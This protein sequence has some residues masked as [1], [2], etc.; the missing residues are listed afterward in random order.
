MYTIVELWLRQESP[1]LLTRKSERGLMYSTDWLV[2]ANTVRAALLTAYM[3]E[4][5]QRL[6]DHVSHCQ[7]FDNICRASL[8]EVCGNC[9]MRQRCP[10]YVDTVNN[11]ITWH[12]L[13]PTVDENTVT[14]YQTTFI[15]KCKLDPRSIVLTKFNIFE[16][17][18]YRCPID[19]FTE[20]GE[21]RYV[22]PLKDLVEV[23]VTSRKVRTRVLVPETYVRTEVAISKLTST[24]LFG[25][26]YNYE[27]VTCFSSKEVQL[28]TEREVSKEGVSKT[29]KGILQLETGQKSGTK[30][31]LYWTFI[32]IP[33]QRK[34]LVDVFK[35]LEKKVVRIGRALSR[36][37]GKF[38]I[39]KVSESTFD[40]FV[41]T[42]LGPYVKYL[43]ECVNVIKN[44][45]KKILPLV[46]ESKL[47]VVPLDAAPT[48]DNTVKMLHI[49]LKDI[50]RKDIKIGIKGSVDKLRL[51][52]A[53]SNVPKLACYQISRG[54]KIFVE[55]QEVDTDLVQ[56][57][58]NLYV[59]GLRT[60]NN[61]FI[62]SGY[63]TLKVPIFS[64]KN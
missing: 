40:T 50:I 33:E 41:K 5:C 8:V 11:V 46:P 16:D 18:V 26:L 14:W 60:G 57:L 44:W 34:E 58:I 4:Q 62:P 36:G 29:L 53:T 45:P 28:L 3:Y 2:E 6:R 64:I 22:I 56:S 55:F 7:R 35:Q 61:I 20:E 10:V 17:A 25:M 47:V 43:E 21:S 32:A 15:G 24:A 51:W 49:A 27:A 37:F 23:A 1:Y 59:T 13:L 42:R 52:S 38:I 39:E 48:L 19:I 31:R 9:N 30:C 63:N 12:S 54:V